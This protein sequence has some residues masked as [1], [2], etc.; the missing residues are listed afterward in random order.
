VLCPQTLAAD[1]AFLGASGVGCAKA[2]AGK[3]TE[4]AMPAPKL[5]I[6]PRKDRR[7]LNADPDSRFGTSFNVILPPTCRS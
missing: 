2:V 7:P 6:A 1:F 4:P 5:T 3:T